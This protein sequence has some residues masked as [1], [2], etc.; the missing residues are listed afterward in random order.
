MSDYLKN[1]KFPEDIKTLNNQELE[2][3]GQEIRKFLVKSVSKTGGHLASNLG[4]VELTIAIHKVFNAPKDK[5][6]FDV[7]HQCYTHKILTGRSRTDT[8]FIR[9]KTSYY[10]KL[11]WLLSS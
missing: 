6:V 11:F 9:R 8:N 2:A 4:V 3:L 5:I 7:S 10:D 1:M